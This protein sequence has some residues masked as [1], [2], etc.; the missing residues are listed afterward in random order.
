MVELGP[1]ARIFTPD[2]I[3]TGHLPEGRVVV[4]DDDHYYMGAVIAERLRT[5]GAPRRL[6]ELGIETVPA[7]GLCG[8]DG[9]EATLACAYTGRERRIAA[10]SVVMVTARLPNDG[11]YRALCERLAPGSEAAP[12][13]LQR[14]GDCDAPA[15]IA[16]AVHAGHRYSRELDAPRDE[17]AL[18]VRREP[19]ISSLGDGRS[20]SA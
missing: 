9:R 7:H 13:S 18:P 3:M 12:A 11:L 16:A 8:F 15:I 2:D 19:M 4:F 6:I 14:I 20:C 17:S 1:P 5:G 10:D